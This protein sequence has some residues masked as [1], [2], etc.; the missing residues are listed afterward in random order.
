[1]SVLLEERLEPARK[2]LHHKKLLWVADIWTHKTKAIKHISNQAKKKRIPL[3]VI[4]VLS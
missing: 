4:M 3:T 2:G 1:L